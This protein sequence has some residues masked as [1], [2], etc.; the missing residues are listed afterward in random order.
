MRLNSTNK[1]YTIDRYEKASIQH[2]LNSL[3][4]SCQMDLIFKANDRVNKDNRKVSI[5]EN[6]LLRSAIEELSGIR[7]KKKHISI[8]QDVFHGYGIRIS[9]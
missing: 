7:I 1:I 5:K 6:R 2:C 8:L 9:W 3:S 4:I